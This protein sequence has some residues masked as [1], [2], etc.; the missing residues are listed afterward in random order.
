[1]S[2]SS[3]RRKGNKSPPRASRRKAALLTPWFWPR[4]T[5]A[6]LLTYCKIIHLCCFKTLRLWQH[7]RETNSN[8]M[9]FVFVLRMFNIFRILLSICSIIFILFGV[10]SSSL[11][12]LFPKSYSVSLEIRVSQFC[13][14][15]HR[16]HPEVPI[17]ELCLRTVPPFHRDAG[18]SQ[19][20]QHIQQATWP[21][22]GPL[23]C[24]T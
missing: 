17:P 4:E 23:L 24:P 12:L 10:D 8:V 9:S 6:G 21:L 1:M 22:P 11:F 3:W 5:H 13:F 14:C 15:L 7:E 16:A 2:S 20:L 19:V 18:I